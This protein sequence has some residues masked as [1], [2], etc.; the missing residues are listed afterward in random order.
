MKIAFRSA[1][2]FFLRIIVIASVYVPHPLLRSQVKDILYTL[3]V[4]LEGYCTCGG[5][6]SI[7]HSLSPPSG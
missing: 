3:A 4:H 7:L 1:Y 2:Y 6:I 5:K